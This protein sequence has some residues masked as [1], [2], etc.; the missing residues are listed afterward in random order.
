MRCAKNGVFLFSS[1]KI[2]FIC[3]PLLWTCVH[4][5]PRGYEGLTH[6]WWWKMLSFN[7]SRK[8]PELFYRSERT[9]RHLSSSSHTGKQCA[10]LGVCL[11]SITIPLKHKMPH[12]GVQNHKAESPA[13]LQTP[14]KLHPN[15]PPSQSETGPLCQDA[16]KG[17]GHWSLLFMECQTSVTFPELRNSP[18]LL[19]HHR[20]HA[21]F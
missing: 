2:K 5:T 10:K 9:R 20:S 18:S 4:R 21:S 3:F 13:S 11:P 7:G 12:S 8:G 19:D 6:E 16:E 1:T 14:W 15:C 17:L